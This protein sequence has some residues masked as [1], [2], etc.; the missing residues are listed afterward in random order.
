MILKIIK[1]YYRK[2]VWSLFKRTVS[3]NIKGLSKVFNLFKIPDIESEVMD[4][5]RLLCW[6]LAYDESGE[7]VLD[8][9]QNRVRTC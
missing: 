2:F 4:V 9:S 5:G 8:T 7:L 6:A 1:Y 3:R